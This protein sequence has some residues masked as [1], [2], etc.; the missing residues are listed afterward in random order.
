LFFRAIKI[1]YLENALTV[2]TFRITHGTGSI[3][4]RYD[5]N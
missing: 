2:Q 3:F 1:N 4:T 5:V